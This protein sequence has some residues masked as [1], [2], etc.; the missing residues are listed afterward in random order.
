[1]MK[2][3][4]LIWI[5]LICLFSA[6]VAK[7]GPVVVDAGKYRKMFNGKGYSDVYGP[8]TV[9][10]VDG[11]EWEMYAGLSGS[12]SRSSKAEWTVVSKDG[13]KI[14]SGTG[15]YGYMNFT[16]PKTL[17]PGN[18]YTLKLTLENEHEDLS[19]NVISQEEANLVTGEALEIVS[20]ADGETLNPKGSSD[21]FYIEF[22]IKEAGFERVSVE[23]KEKNKSRSIWQSTSNSDLDSHKGGIQ[24][25]RKSIS[26][27]NLTPGTTYVVTVKQGKMSVS[28]E[29]TVGKITG[30]SIT[31]SSSSSNDSEATRLR[32]E[33]GSLSTAE[34]GKK[35]LQVIN[36]AISTLSND[37][38][39]G[40]KKTGER[41]TENGTIYKKAYLGKVDS[42]S[43]P[44]AMVQ[45]TRNTELDAT[46]E[47]VLS[48]LVEDVEFLCEK[49]NLPAAEVRVLP[50]YI[51]TT[52][53][54]LNKKDANFTIIPFLLVRDESVVGEQ[55]Y[56]YFSS[57]SEGIFHEN[58]KSYSL[59]HRGYIFTRDSSVL[60]VMRYL[61]GYAGNSKSDNAVLEYFRTLSVN[62][63]MVK[64]SVSMDEL[65]SAKLAI[66][67]VTI[68][69]D[70]NVN[71]RNQ[72]DMEGE[73]IG[74]AGKGK[75]Y[76]LYNIEE[77]GWYEIELDDGTH[78]YIGNWMG[79][80]T[81]K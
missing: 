10:M 63:E 23:V 62:E 9:A 18:E 33:S 70:S 53:G 12:T 56:I 55:P 79:M 38:G 7:L 58:G 40:T 32:Q 45:T 68:R 11:G 54:S 73:I 5:V 17:V 74:V 77:N 43:F 60:K 29:F 13:A 64:S 37:I 26:Y 69:K 75:V 44:V 80:K 51:F 49:A 34:K 67:T 41:K 4:L 21:Y 20:F 8:F 1:M 3:M 27:S 2:R 6:A 47:R 52:E 76:S 50:E 59:E 42:N 24:P 16:L 14:G 19:F 65:G 66:G 22:D 30:N 46:I 39:R 36:D 61:Y 28:K 81:E 31:S 48:Y 57:Q 78:G 35:V 72:P 25:T 71:V 15:R